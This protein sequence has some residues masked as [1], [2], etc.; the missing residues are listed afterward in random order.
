VETA[1][2]DGICI[3]WAYC[4]DILWNKTEEYCGQNI[5]MILTERKM[6]KAEWSGKFHK[7]F[8][9]SETLGCCWYCSIII[10]M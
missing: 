10:L 8:S 6:L 1:A 9:S 7:K 4:K 5:S 3:S 2:G